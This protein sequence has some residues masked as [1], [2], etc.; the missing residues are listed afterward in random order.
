VT[1][2]SVYPENLHRFF[3]GISNPG[4]SIRQNRARGDKK[5]LASMTLGGI[6]YI[7]FINLALIF[8]GPHG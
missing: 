5:H 8:G 2:L 1:S 7:E 4:E 6:K 3:T